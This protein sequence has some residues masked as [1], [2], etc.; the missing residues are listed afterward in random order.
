MKWLPRFVLNLAKVEQN[1]RSTDKQKKRKPPWLLGVFV[2]VLFGGLL[3]LQSSNLWKT[4]TVDSAS[5]T[6][7]L[8]ALS[9]LNFIAFVIFA[10]ILARSLLKLRQERREFQI[11]SKIK[12]KLIIYFFLVSILPLIAM[13]IFSYLYMNRALENWFSDKPKAVFRQ[14]QR[15]Q[16]E[17]QEQKR[18]RLGETARALA[19]SLDGRTVT[20]EDLAEIARAG[21]MEHL[22]IIGSDGKSINSSATILGRKENEALDFV[23][24]LFSENRFE[25]DELVDS[26]ANLAYTKMSGGRRLVI[27]PKPIKGQA[28][29]NDGVT[30]LG[31]D[32]VKSP[33]EEYDEIKEQS[34]GV[35]QIGLTTVGLLTFLLIFAASWF[36]IYVAKGLT[37]PIRALAEGADEIAQG[38]LGHK[39]EVIAEDELEMLVSAFNEMSG[40]LEAN[41]EEIEDRRRYIETILQSLST[42]V[43][44]L[45]I[46]NRITTI[47]RA[48]IDMLKLENAQFTGL[49]LKKL[50]NKE[51]LV[52]LERLISRAKRI[53]QALE[54]TT[55]VKESSGNNGETEE[56]LPVALTAS[57]LPNEGGSVLVIED[58]SELIAAQRASAWREVARRMAHEIKNP[59]TPIQLSAER[60]AKRFA[61]QNGEKELKLAASSDRVELKKGNQEAEVIREGTATI[62]REVYSLKSMVD[63]FSRFARLPNAKLEEGD[64][65]KVIR[66]AVALYKDREQA[67]SIDLDLAEDLPNV[68]IDNEQLKRVFV[69]LID[70]AIEAFEKEQADKVVGIKSFNDPARDLII[71]EIVDSGTGIAPSELGK[72]FQPYF[73]TKGRGT[74]LGLAIVQRIITE[75]GGKIRAGNKSSSGAKF[76]IELPNSN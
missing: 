46:D 17:A 18:N 24:K 61:S 26:D 32:S 14:A 51:N 68:M 31:T 42:G 58:L 70:N 71:A 28:R 59:L 72:L 27:F 74:G 63:E 41:S 22:L 64:L 8:Y 62:L 75:H 10:F 6:L 52:I 48:A 11:G 7:L 66:Q 44:S 25:K 15:I 20:D 56:G 39:V 67:V 73:S 47:N 53:G 36:A 21:E 4:L 29:Q 9:S 65:N 57:G 19:K 5:D 30:S 3:L 13:A 60:I 45:D 43:I 37:R 35:R 49:E 55:L 34:R 50:V 12:T 23:L 40:K 54:Q 33:L 2:L 16:D 69:N 76:V 38:N 1:R